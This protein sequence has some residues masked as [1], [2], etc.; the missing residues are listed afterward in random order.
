[1]FQRDKPVL[2][3]SRSLLSLE[4]NLLVEN[5]FA[6]L[7]ERGFYYLPLAYRIPTGYQPGLSAA[8]I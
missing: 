5:H 3:L 7:D 2:P 8:M 1:M 4:V 6:F